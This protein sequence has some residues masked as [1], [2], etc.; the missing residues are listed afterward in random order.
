MHVYLLTAKRAPGRATQWWDQ[1]LNKANKFRIFFFFTENIVKSGLIPRLCSKLFEMLPGDKEDQKVRPPLLI[2][3]QWN[4]NKYSSLRPMWRWVTWRFTMRKCLTCSTGEIVV[5][6]T[7]WKWGKV[8]AIQDR[9]IGNWYIRR[10]HKV[11]GPY[12][13]GLS[14]LAVLDAQRI[15]DLMAD[16]NKSRTVAATNM[17]TESSRSHAVFTIMI[18]FDIMWVTV[19]VIVLHCLL[20]LSVIETA[21]FKARRCPESRLWTWPGQSELTRPGLRGPGWRRDPTSTSHSQPWD[22]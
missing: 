17:N 18:T 13:E 9:R 20:S 22:W 7:V 8:H 21:E 16:G 14:Q 19:L 4:F 1:S 15:E 11:L 5:R 6:R 12:V 3:I 2:Q 10:E